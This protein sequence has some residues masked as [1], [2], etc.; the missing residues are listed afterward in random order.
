[1]QSNIEDIKK[2]VKVFNGENNLNLGNKYVNDRNLP[3][4]TNKRLAD[5]LGKIESATISIDT[6]FLILGA[7]LLQ[8]KELLPHGEFMTFINT[9][10]RFSVKTANNCMNAY[11]VVNDFPTLKNLNKSLLYIIGEKKFPHELRTLL[12]G[13]IMGDID[14]TS[15]ELM[16]LQTAFINGEITP[17][18][19]EFSLR[20]KA[21]KN[22]NILSRWDDLAQRFI[23]KIDSDRKGVKNL[24]KR[25]V[26]ILGS[27]SQKEVDGYGLAIDRILANAITSLGKLHKK[28]ENSVVTT[29]KE[30]GKVVLA[31]NR[32]EVKLG[33]SIF[34]TGLHDLLN[35]DKLF[36]STVENEEHAPV[37][38]PNPVYPKLMP[39]LPAK[40]LIEYKVVEG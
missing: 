1:M 16:A 7:L 39:E 37:N 15:T 19:N 25:Q 3:D 26:D 2:L 22:I 8:V 31:G 36:W 14:M 32:T 38:Y 20:L 13:S 29:H 21:Q 4:K 5:L 34:D 12:A 11:R 28:W 27:D 33:D 24:Q 23:K 35:Q 6:W 9:F 18:G 17:D 40:L 10:C 30:V